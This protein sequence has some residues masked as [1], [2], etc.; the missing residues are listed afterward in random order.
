MA[1]RDKV[2]N[3]LGHATREFGVPCLYQP[4]GRQA[5]ELLCIFRR[6]HVEV[7][8]E[9]GAEIASEMPVVEFRLSD[10]PADCDPRPMRDLVTV[11][12]LD[13]VHETARQYLVIRAQRDGEGAVL[14]VL[15]ERP[16]ESVD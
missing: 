7:D 5:L 4:D 2:Q 13:G 10:L 16:I 3:L 12:A 11:P 9:T 1:W 6:A 14:C 15:H 8:P